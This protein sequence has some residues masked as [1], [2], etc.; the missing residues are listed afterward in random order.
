MFVYIQTFFLDALVNAQSE[1]LFDRTEEDDAAQGSPAVHTEDTQ[2]LSTE[3]AEAVAIEQ[4]GARREQ[5]NTKGTEDTA[6]AVNGGGTD[7]IIDVQ[8]LVDEGDT[9]RKDD[10][11]EGTDDE[12]T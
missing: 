3:R 10:T 1:E 8:F 7:R 12:G 5:T 6:D 4:A 2:R 9:Q 11:A